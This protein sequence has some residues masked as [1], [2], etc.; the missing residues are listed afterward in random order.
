[1]L[2]GYIRA[3]DPDPDAR[4]CWS[5]VPGVRVYLAGMDGSGRPGMPGM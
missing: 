2:Y 3:M 1:M 5:M 4:D